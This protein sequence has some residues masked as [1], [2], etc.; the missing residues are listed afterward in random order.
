MILATMMKKWRL[1][2]ETSHKD[3]S[4]LTGVPSRALA[5]FENG[6]D[7]KAGQLAKILK[8]VLSSPHGLKFEEAGV[9]EPKLQLLGSAQLRAYKKSCDEAIA[10][11]M[12]LPL[13]VTQAPND[14]DPG[15]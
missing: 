14:L 12:L 15:A 10:T 13:E 4:E 7:I 11:Q 5:A 6:A 2:T 3:V 9:A 8:F 1:M